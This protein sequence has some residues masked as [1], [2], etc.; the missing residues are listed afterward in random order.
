[1]KRMAL[2]ATIILV[3]GVAGCGSDSPTSPGNAPTIFT[4]PLSALNEVPLVTNSETSGRGTV[5]ITFNTVKDASGAITSATADFNVSMNSFPNGSQANLAH[6]H[7]GA[8][9]V[10]GSP[11][12][13]TGLTAGT[14]I[15]MPNGSAT[16]SF[17]GIAVTPADATAILANPQNFYF[18]VHTTLN[19]SGA[20]RG[21]LR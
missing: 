8:T 15:P 7:P 12:V 11:L 9:G 20:L 3:L 17:T 19:P 6:I 14:G 4:I 16:F 1:M 13:N 5:V 21:Q 2:I 18:N 10:A